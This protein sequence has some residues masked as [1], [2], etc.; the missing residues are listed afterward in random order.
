METVLGNVVTREVIRTLIEDKHI[1]S[2]RKTYNKLH[3]KKKSTFFK[4]NVANC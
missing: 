4:F 3:N 1:I 2:I